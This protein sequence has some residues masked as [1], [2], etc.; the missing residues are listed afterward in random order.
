MPIPSDTTCFSCCLGLRVLGFRVGCHCNYNDGPSWLLPSRKTN[1]DIAPVTAASASAKLTFFKHHLY[2]L[3]LQC[4]LRSLVKKMLLQVL[5]CHCSS[6]SI[7]TQKLST[8]LR[9]ARSCPAVQLPIARVMA[10]SSSPRPGRVHTVAK[11]YVYIYIYTCMDMSKT[12]LLTKWRAGYIC[13]YI[14]ICIN[15]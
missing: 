1:S 11:I 15:I 3:Q 4:I 8:R 13:I 12:V 10:F 14:Y 7:N 9:K 2:R 5:H 6:V